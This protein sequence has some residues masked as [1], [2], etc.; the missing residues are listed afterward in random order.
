M[1]ELKYIAFLTVQEKSS[2]FNE[3][4]HYMQ[5]KTSLAFVLTKTPP[6]LLARY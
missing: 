4:E 5:S 3:Y 2:E 6:N 1:I